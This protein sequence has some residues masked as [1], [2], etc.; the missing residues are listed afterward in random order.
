MTYP[1]PLE[2]RILYRLDA[3]C[4][5]H[6]IG[7]E[8]QL[9]FQ[10]QKAREALGYLD[11]NVYMSCA[12][13]KPQAL[14][15]MFVKAGVPGEYLGTILDEAQKCGGRCISVLARNILSENE[16]IN[17]WLADH[18]SVKGYRIICGGKTII[19]YDKEVIHADLQKRF[20]GRRKNL[21]SMYMRIE[22]Q[23]RVQKR[24]SVELAGEAE[25]VEDHSDIHTEPVQMEFF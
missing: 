17:N 19:T 22:K 4:L 25:P 6:A 23:L 10:S 13:S 5:E 18:G 9:S 7:A 21:V 12:Y 3:N 14:S 8:I 16:V 2:R 1:D 24:R 11:K 20:E 15:Q